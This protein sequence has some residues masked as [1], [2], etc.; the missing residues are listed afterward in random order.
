LHTDAVRSVWLGIE[1]HRL[2]IDNVVLPHPAFVRLANV[3]S[4]LGILLA[5]TP[6][7]RFHFAEP[8]E[9]VLMRTMLAD[10]KLALCINENPRQLREAV[11]EESIGNEH[12]FTFVPVLS[13][14][15]NV[16]QDRRIEQRLAPLL[17]RIRN[18]SSNFF[19]ID[20][21]SICEPCD[22]P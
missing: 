17:R 10:F 2:T 7:D 16:L 13:R 12:Q 11:Q 20:F 21:E 8:F 14:E 19:H 6:H 1:R 22:V 5:P 15:L 18:T 9:V 3:D 4:D